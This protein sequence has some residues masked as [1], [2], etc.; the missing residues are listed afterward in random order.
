MAANIDPRAGHLAAER[1]GVLDDD[2]RSA[3]H[4]GENDARVDGQVVEVVV[5]QLDLLLIR[6]TGRTDFQNGSA[7][8]HLRVTEPRP[9]A[10]PGHQ[11]SMLRR[12][13]M[14]APS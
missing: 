11:A 12:A 1:D 10:T 3:S 5:D 6:G 13:S 4:P 2:D 9:A 7:D 14:R 8:A